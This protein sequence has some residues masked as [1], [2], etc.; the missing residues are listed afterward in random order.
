MTQKIF[1]ASDHAGVAFKTRIKEI[2]SDVQWVDCGPHD[3]VSVDYPDYAE[4]VCRSVAKYEDAELGILICG[5]GIGMSIAANKYKGI[6]AAAV[7]NPTSA[8][9]ARIHNHANVLCLGARFLAPEYGCEIILSWLEATP[10]TEKRH[11]DRIRK[12]KE[13]ETRWS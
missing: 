13:I 6:R 2:L 4:K 10:S 12:I 5:S 9:L 3:S 8:E 1:I 11:L 7:S